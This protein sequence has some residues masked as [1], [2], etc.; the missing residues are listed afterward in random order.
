MHF[1]GTAETERVAKALAIPT[2]AIFLTEHGPVAYRRS[3]RGFEAAPL[4]L[5]KRNHDYAEVLAG[6]SE[7][8]EVSRTDKA[9]IEEG[10]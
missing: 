4:K 5:G 2:N 8:D 6:L 3:A 1:R 10:R 9:R 7:G